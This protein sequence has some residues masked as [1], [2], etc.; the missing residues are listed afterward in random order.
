M[1]VIIAWDDSDGWYDH[2]MPP[3]VNRSDTPLDFLCG[4]RSDG[5]GARCGYGPRLPLLV[6]SP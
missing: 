3:I 4:G 5:P 1:A 2:V 6:M